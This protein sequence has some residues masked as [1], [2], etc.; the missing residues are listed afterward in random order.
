MN[1]TASSS[2]H[3][4]ATPPPPAAHL[5]TMLHVGGESGEDPRLDAG[6]VR[7]A[8]DRPYRHEVVV[9]LRDRRARPYERRHQLLD[10][11]WWAGFLLAMLALQVA[12]RAMGL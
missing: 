12:V 3:R 1:R 8:L 11:A 2:R 4:P 6:L 9:H 5:A 7:A 10:M